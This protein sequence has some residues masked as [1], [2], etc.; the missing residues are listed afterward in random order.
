M[1]TE[2]AAPAPAGTGAPSLRV[3]PLVFALASVNGATAACATH[4][5]AAT[6]VVLSDYYALLAAAA[7]AADGWVIKVMGDGVLLGFPT[8]RAG[9]AVEVLRAAQ[10]AGTRRW[11]DFDA[12]CRVTIR[13]GTG[14]VVRARLGPPGDER[15]DIYGDALNRLFKTPPSEELLLLPELRA[16]IASEANPGVGRLNFRPSNRRK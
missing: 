14:P 11:Q 5:D 9:E 10:A 7:A 1:K 12:R 16:L 8:P 15:D 6:V 2:R 3:E 4:G 13:A